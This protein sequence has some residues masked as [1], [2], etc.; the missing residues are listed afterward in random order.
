LAPQDNLVLFSKSVSVVPTHDNGNLLYF[1]S[2][3]FKFMSALVLWLRSYLVGAT[4]EIILIVRTVILCGIYLMRHTCSCASN[5]VIKSQLRNQF[6]SLV[7][8]CFP[9]MQPMKIAG[10]ITLST[11]FMTDLSSKGEMWANAFWVTTVIVLVRNDTTASSFFQ[12]FQRVEGT[13]I[14]AIYAF[15][16]YHFLGCS[17]HAQACSWRNTTFALVIWVAFCST[18]RDS[19]AH[20]YAAQVA[21]ITPIMLFLGPTPATIVGAWNRVMMTLLGVTLYLCIDN[22]LFPIRIGDTV[23]TG[24]VGCLHKTAALVDR[25]AGGVGVVVETVSN[26]EEESLAAG[27]VEFIK[28]LKSV[29]EPSSDTGIPDVGMTDKRHLDLAPS[30]QLKDTQENRSTEMRSYVAGT[31]ESLSVAA[32]VVVTVQ[33]LQEAMKLAPFEPELWYRLVRFAHLTMSC[34]D[35]CT[36]TAEMQTF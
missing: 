16:M 34:C 31:E 19:K 25:L 27:D 35:F 28:G 11:L 23:R 26:T 4:Q 8:L 22:L 30:D 24:I 15:S 33:K 20:F 5:D 3:L 29:A 36:V 9:Y 21:G 7:G 1:A 6:N 32:G 10:A 12:G 18:F 17:E 2:N 13:V 14:G